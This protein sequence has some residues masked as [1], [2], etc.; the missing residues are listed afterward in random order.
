VVNSQGVVVRTGWSIGRM[1]ETTDLP[2]G[3]YTLVCTRDNATRVAR[4]VRL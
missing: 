3:V 4:F 1:V 2:A